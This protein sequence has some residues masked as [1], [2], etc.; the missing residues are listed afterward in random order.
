MCRAQRK[1][2]PIVGLVAKVEIYPP[3]AR[4]LCRPDKSG[5]LAMTISAFLCHCEPAI[6]AG[7]RGHDLA[8]GEL[9]INRFNN[10]SQKE[11]VAKRISTVILCLLDIAYAIRAV[12]NLKRCASD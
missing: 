10:I 6:G 11:K 8:P 9:T 4:L 7:Q 5:L 3:M 1:R 12:F 2:I